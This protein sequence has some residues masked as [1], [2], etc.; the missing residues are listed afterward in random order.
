ME[1]ERYVD[2]H[3]EDRVLLHCAASRTVPLEYGLTYKVEV[4]RYDWPDGGREMLIVLDNE[5][6]NLADA[7]DKAYGERPSRRPR[8]T[9][10][11][12]RTTH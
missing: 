8:V 10:A 9:P 2:C 6:L 7:G 12:D 5:V 4:K 1:D 3:P 11:P